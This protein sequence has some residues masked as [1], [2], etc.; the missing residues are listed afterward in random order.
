MSQAIHQQG[1]SLNSSVRV[2]AVATR[3]RIVSAAERLFAKRGIDATTL[4]EINRAARQRNRS[5]VQYHFGNKQGVIHAILD[6]HTPG[7]ELRRHAMLDEI[8]TKGEPSL[9]ALAEALVLPVAEKLDDPDGGLAFLRLNAQL[10]GHPSFPL[11]S[12]H[13]QRINRGADRLNRLIVA[14]APN[15]PEALWTP[16]WLLLI[17]LLFHGMA[18]YAQLLEAGSP[19][20]DAP[21]RGLFVSNLI[22]SVV[23]ILE[24]PISSATASQIP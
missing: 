17:G 9:R 23:A 18:D 8:E 14:T 13:A 2:D 12:L 6:K 20:H 7:I 11:L 21:S 4:A 16:R 19:A 10:I 22:D 5:A 15:W 1:D 3:A 24:A